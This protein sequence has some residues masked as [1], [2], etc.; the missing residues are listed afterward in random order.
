MGETFQYFKDQ[1]EID[2]LST[3]QTYTFEAQEILSEILLAESDYKKKYQTQ[4]D[5]FNNEK[6]F[7]ETSSQHR[8]ELL[9][10]R[11]QANIAYERGYKFLNKIGYYFAGKE[12]QYSVTLFGRQNVTFHMNID[13]FLQ[14]KEIHLSGFKLLSSKTSILSK[15][16]ELGIKGEVWGKDISDTSS[17]YNLKLYDSYKG[18]IEYARKVLRESNKKDYNQGQILE[19]YLAFSE[20]DNN[21]SILSQIAQYANEAGISHLGGAKYKDLQRVYKEFFN[22][23]KKIYE[24]LRKQTNSTGF[25]AKGDTEVEGQIK[26][27]GA[28]IFSYDTITRQ[29]DKFIRISEKINYA[30]LEAK[31]KSEVTGKAQ[32]TLLQNVNEILKSVMAQF[33]ATSTSQSILNA[34]ETASSDSDLTH[35]VYSI[36]SEL[37]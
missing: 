30:N 18:A 1:T 32:D 22:Q 34:I 28:S 20:E 36:I 3:L 6:K 16:K 24:S 8:Q 37:I 19:G 27:E 29:L 17:R 13:E 4:I 12:W 33:Q 25:W 23:R 21:L 9:S 5:I 35:D 10:Y 7:T 11:E 31:L 26:G 15:M 14:L 2:I